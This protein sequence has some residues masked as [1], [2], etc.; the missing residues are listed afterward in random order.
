ME[1]LARLLWEM[2]VA[3]EISP[4]MSYILSKLG[5]DVV[6]MEEFNTNTDVFPQKAFIHLIRT[7]DEARRN[8]GLRME[9]YLSERNLT[10]HPAASLPSVRGRG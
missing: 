8:W 4:E 2:N 9:T 1:L 5:C 3:H 10:L 6:S 7:A